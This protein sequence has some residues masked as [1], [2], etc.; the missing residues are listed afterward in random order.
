MQVR[1]VRVEDEEGGHELSFTDWG[2][3]DAARTVVCVHGLTRNGRDFDR[4]AEALSADA[5]VICPDM[6][7]RGRSDRLADPEHYALPTYIVHMLQL[8]DRLALGP[9]DWVGT[10][11]GGLIGMGVAAADAG[12]IRRLVLNDVGPFLPRAALERINRYLGLDLRF[13]DIAALE[14]HLRAIHAGFGP[15]TDAQ[16]RQLAEHVALT[17][18]DGTLALNY[19]QRL[20]V[21]LKRP[22]IGDVDLWPVWDQIRCPVLVLRGVESDL[23][24][25]ETAAQMARRGPHAEIVEID[26]TGHAPVLMARDQIE[27]VRNWLGP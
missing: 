14:A 13:A 15:L 20:A 16:W 23:L 9:V 21:P 3:P 27:I 24:T 19:D 1:R 7:G 8:I 25:A 11:M 18:E 12:K 2:A 10:S 22:P 4:L 5:R 17:L 26:G 6:V